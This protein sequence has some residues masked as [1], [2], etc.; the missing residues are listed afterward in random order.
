[1][2]GKLFK[3]STFKLNFWKVKLSQGKYKNFHKSIKNLWVT[4]LR[5]PYWL[6]A[7][8]VS[9]W[10]L[11]GKLRKCML[12]T[13][14]LKQVERFKNIWVNELPKLGLKNIKKAWLKFTSNKEIERNIFNTW[15][16]WIRGWFYEVIESLNLQLEVV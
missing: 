16:D 6:K 5:H 2:Q 3:I 7:K 14:A 12:V 11:G 9:N 15:S 4:T 8:K 13:F 10:T 1:M